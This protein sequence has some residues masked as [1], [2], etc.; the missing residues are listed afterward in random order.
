VVQYISLNT[1]DLPDI[2]ALALGPAALGLGHIYK[3]N[4]S[5]PWYNYYLVKLTEISI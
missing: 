3:A 1:I 2:Y 5:W 4:P